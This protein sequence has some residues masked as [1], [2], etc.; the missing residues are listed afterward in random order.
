M[1]FQSS[2]SWR[3]RPW[4]SPW[5]HHPEGN[6]LFHGSA[7]LISYDWSEQPWLYQCKRFCKLDSRRTHVTGC[8][9]VLMSIF[10]RCWSK[11]GYCVAPVWEWTEEVGTINWEQ[12][13]HSTNMETAKKR[14]RI[15]GKDWTRK[16]SMLIPATYHH[17]ISICLCTVTLHVDNHEGNPRR[18]Q[19]YDLP[20]L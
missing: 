13:C 20:R 17:Q 9:W 19:N 11:A 6:R 1:L 7:E 15:K 16:V 2:F 4:L 3:R 12:E 8:H 5:L 10:A 18:V 14:A